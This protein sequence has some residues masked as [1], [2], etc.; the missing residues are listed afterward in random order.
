MR[1]RKLKKK[2]QNFDIC[3]KK[4][5]CERINIRKK[6]HKMLMESQRKL[7]KS[8]GKVMEKSWNSMSKIWKT[9][10]YK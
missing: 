7:E 2:Y 10:R 6:V 8:Q 3:Q 9:Q 1:N 4:F 5:N